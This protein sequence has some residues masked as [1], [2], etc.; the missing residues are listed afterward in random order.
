MPPCSSVRHPLADRSESSS[1]P[2]TRA[3]AARLRSTR[4][5]RGTGCRRSRRH[6]IDVLQV[7]VGKLCNQTCRHC[8]VD[9]GPDRRE[10]M[11]RETVDEVPGGCSAQPRHPDARHHRRRSRAEPALPL[12]RRAKRATLGRQVID[13]CNLT[14]LMLPAQDDLPE[15]LAEHEVEIIGSLPSFRRRRPTPSAATACSRSRIAALRR[16][17]AGWATARGHRAGAQP[18]HQSGRRLPARPTRR[19]S[20][21]T[22]AASLLRRTA[23]CFDRLFT[24]TNMPISRF[25]EC[26]ERTGNTDRYME[27]LVAAFN[28]AAVG[29]LMCRTHVL[30]RLGRPPLRLRFQPDARAAGR[31]TRPQTITDLLTPASWRTAW[32]PARTASAAPPGP[33]PAVADRPRPEGKALG[34]RL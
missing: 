31:S 19:R 17:N 2:S 21:A 28:P 15:F 18:R 4:C 32:S 6:R 16:L 1:R 20:S 29:G 9:A 23:S 22:T 30:G 8:H 5:S 24:I 3:A 12:A 25:L 13:R 33:A 34:S 27:L 11:T 26:L 14:V 7:N 10:V